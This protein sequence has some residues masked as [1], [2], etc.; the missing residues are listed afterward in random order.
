MT[1]LGAVLHMI[2]GTAAVRASPLPLAQLLVRRCRAV[3]RPVSLF[4]RAY[5][6]ENPQRTYQFYGSLYRHPNRRDCLTKLSAVSTK[7][8]PVLIYPTITL[9]NLT[10]ANP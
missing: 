10:H 4:V 2:G 5:G 3:L 7:L 1:D 8:I 6:M 9:M